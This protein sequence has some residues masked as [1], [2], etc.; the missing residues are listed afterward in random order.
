M[1]NRDNAVLI[2]RRYYA[3]TAAQ[4]GAMH[5]H[6]GDADPRTL[7]MVRALLGMVEARSA[8]DVGAG[9]GRAI[10]YLL[11]HMPGLSVRGIEPVGTHRA[12]DSEEWGSRGSHR[13][14][15]R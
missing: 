10:R 15:R 11:D 9:T 4:Y 1:A 7:S 6:E 3:E 8:L 2:Q 5:S 13:A 14:G 12:G